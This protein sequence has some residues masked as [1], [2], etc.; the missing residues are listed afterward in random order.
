MT[1]P[2]L[3]SAALVLASGLASM[4]VANHKSNVP[5]YD[6]A[7]IGANYPGW[8]SE[9]AC[10]VDRPGQGCRQVVDSCGKHGNP[11]F[12]TQRIFEALKAAASEGQEIPVHLM[13]STGHFI[14]IQCTVGG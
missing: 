11:I 1:K 14:N 5:D 6:F 2:V 7:T 8:P 4:A 10:A 9:G 12:T 13:S 3:L